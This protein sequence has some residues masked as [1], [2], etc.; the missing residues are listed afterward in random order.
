MYKLLPAIT[1]AS[2]LLKIPLGLTCFIYVYYK[3]AINCLNY[4]P[5]HDEH[6]KVKCL[7]LEN[8][9]ATLLNPGIKSWS[10]FL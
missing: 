2:N 4:Q 3:A 5:H 7:S 1:I 8:V 10:T 6:W 9:L